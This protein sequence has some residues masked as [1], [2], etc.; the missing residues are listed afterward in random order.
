MLLVG[1]SVFTY[2]SGPPSGYS[3]APGDANCTSC[4]SDYS[5]VTSGT[6]WGN[7]TLTR[8]GGLSN[9]AANSANAMTLS[10]SSSTSTL[11]GFQL[12]ALPSSATSSSASVGTFSVGSSSDVQTTSSTSP[13]RIYLEHTS[14]GSAA[15]SGSKSWNFNWQTPTGFT[16]GTT[17]Y[18]VV[19]EADGNTSST[20]DYIYLKTFTATVLPVTWLDFSAKEI[21][22]EV[23]LNWSTAQEINNQK[24]EIEQSFDGEHFL[25]I[26]EIEGKGN[27]ETKSFYVFRTALNSVKTFYRIK[28]IDF[29]GKES[30]S[31]IVSYLH[32]NMLE[33]N[34][35]V[36][37]VNKKLLFSEPQSIERVRVF[38][39][40][41]S[42]IQDNP[43]WK[44]NSLSM[45]G[46]NTGLY[47]I[48]VTG[49]SGKQWMK[50]VLYQ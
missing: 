29:D 12:I 7:I 41:G 13:N 8:A 24:F 15:S 18:V 49:N 35:F 5:A 37:A 6:T 33:P 42:L 9:A 32:N 20:G 47:L 11:F 43:N 50:K 22:G 44:G 39:V 10:F 26:G 16:G 30:Y 31:T 14:A 19:N 27:K 1:E 40:G 2:S 21:D 36:D 17:F 28:Q 34:L 45:D 25:N 4:H 3:N 38:S 48:E 23:Q 46:M